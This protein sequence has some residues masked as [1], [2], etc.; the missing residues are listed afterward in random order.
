[1]LLQMY[2]NG[3]TWLRASDVKDPFLSDFYFNIIP[4]ITV[5]LQRE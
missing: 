3:L 1:M 2:M 5:K 4:S